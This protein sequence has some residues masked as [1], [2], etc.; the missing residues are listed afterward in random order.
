MN[1][2]LRIDNSKRSTF[3]SC[4]R[5]FYWQ[6]CRHLKTRFGS[7]ALRYG[8]T[9]HAGLDAFY[10][11][12]ASRGWTRD[13]GALHAAGTAMKTE[14]DEITAT[15]GQSFFDDYRS[16]TNC[17][18]ALIQYCDRFAADEGI[19]VVNRTETPFMLDMTPSEGEHDL[20][21]RLE[22]F[23]FTGVIDGEIY[24]NERYWVLEHKTTGQPLATQIS[25]LHRSAQVLGYSYA[26]GTWLDAPP[27]GA[28][29]NMHHLS[30]YKSK[31][32]GNYGEPKIDFQRSPQIFS[33]QDL[34]QWRV[35]FL[36]VAQSIQ[37]EYKRA[38]WPMCHDSC[39]Q[40]GSCPYIMLCEQNRS[41]EDTIVPDTHFF[42]GEEWD[43]A[44]GLE[45][46]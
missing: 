12:V 39:Y 27:E 40:Y 26:A 36:A 3:V 1:E 23:L 33:A 44:R 10:K 20:F 35:S 46:L 13:G 38:L 25:R 6:Y 42:E 28:M 24:L 9:W 15:S 41:C 32:T 43:P 31:T 16:L 34:L 4:P 37:D 45:V 21:P 14:W 7:S 30:A 2:P 18:N 29:I 11:D 19:L 22:P 17:F 8:S 5:K